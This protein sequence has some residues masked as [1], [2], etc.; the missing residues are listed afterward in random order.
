MARHNLEQE[1]QMGA[2]AIPAD[3][4]QQPVL[5]PSL[6]SA[7]LESMAK[8][9]KEFTKGFEQE[10][11]FVD[12]AAIQNRFAERSKNSTVWH[13]PQLYSCSGRL[14]EMEFLEEPWL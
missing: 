7:L 3:A 13:V 11:N 12:E 9:I 1:F 6:N 5:G 2:L 14:L 4:D 8:Q 10:L